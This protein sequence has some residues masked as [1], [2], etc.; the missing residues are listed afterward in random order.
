MGK[1]EWRGFVFIFVF[2]FLLGGTARV[3]EDKEG[4]GGKWNCSARCDIPKDLIKIMLLIKNISIFVMLKRL[5]TKKTVEHYSL[6]SFGFQEKNRN[7]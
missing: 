2:S 6:I 3:G 5:F 4:L 1:K 7:M